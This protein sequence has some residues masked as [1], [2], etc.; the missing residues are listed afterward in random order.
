MVAAAVKIAGQ[1]G[2]TRS[3]LG[4]A[5][6]NLTR[7]LET[8]CNCG[9]RRVAAA[10][11]A[12]TG[13]CVGPDCPKGL[14][15]PA[16]APAPRAA[17]GSI[18]LSYRRRQGTPVVVAAAAAA[19]VAPAP[20][21][22]GL[23]IVDPAI[24]GPH[25]WRFLHIAAALPPSRHRGRESWRAVLEALRVALPCPECTGH[26]Q[27]WHREHPFRTMMGGSATRRTAM[28]WVLEL[29]N[30]VNRRRGVAAWTAAQVD[31]SVAGTTA[32]DA[33]AALDAAIAAGVGVGLRAAAERVLA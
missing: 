21:D 5:V 27:A 10:V 15:A 9:K 25:I 8:M 30:D 6:V 20:V 3:R 7:L 16:P 29:H 14:I 23:P 31:A 24:W 19:P 18:P 12:P 28:R 11:S 22:V 26:Y 13:G 32:A 17:P 4:D 33:R 2:A 1:R